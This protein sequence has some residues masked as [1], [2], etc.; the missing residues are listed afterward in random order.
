MDK[1]THSRS[2]FAGILAALRT[3]P[4]LYITDTGYLIDRGIDFYSIQRARKKN[5]RPKIRRRQ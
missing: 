3:V 2:L 5:Q 4:D 1:Y